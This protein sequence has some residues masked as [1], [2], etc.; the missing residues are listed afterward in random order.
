LALILSTMIVKGINTPSG[1]VQSPQFFCIQS[2]GN[3]VPAP[4]PFRHPIKA[5]FLD[6]VPTKVRE[7]LKL[8]LEEWLNFQS[9]REITVLWVDTGESD[10][11]FD[12]NGS[13]I[14]T[15]S[16]GKAL[17]ASGRVQRCTVSLGLRA[18][19]EGESEIVWTHSEMERMARHVWG[20]VFGL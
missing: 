10:V 8:T 1:G 5:R 2:T 3:D 16:L 11:R 20:H 17:P 14:T 19:K 12:L 7:I 6:G 13:G 15:C 4:W 9:A 18:W